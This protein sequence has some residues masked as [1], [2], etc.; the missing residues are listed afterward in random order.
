MTQGTD[1]TTVAGGATFSGASNNE[2]TTTFATS[3]YADRLT[4]V[5][6]SATASAELRGTYRVF[7]RQKK[8]ASGSTMHGT[9]RIAGIIDNPEVTI[10][11]STNFMWNDYGLLQIPMGMQGLSDGYGPPLGALGISC[12]FRFNRT[13]GTGSLLTDYIYLVPADTELSTVHWPSTPA[14]PNWVYDGP[15]DDVYWRGT[16]GV[17][18]A[19]SASGGAFPDYIGGLPM[20]SPNQANR[21]FF[22][23]MDG[24][25]TASTVLAV[26]YWPRYL[27]MRPVT[28]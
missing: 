25:V 27:S 22:A 5:L 23:V 15:N 24:A 13:S 14:G 7:A 26:S 19:V 28:T 4:A 1:T 11:D 10:P 21:V 12:A 17:A 3:S 16:A 2:S 20:V 8:S 6:P 9:L 18:H